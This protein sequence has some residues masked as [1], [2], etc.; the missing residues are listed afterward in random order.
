M[1]RIKE[2]LMDVEEKIVD[3]ID[4]GAK[5]DDEIYAYVNM[6]VSVSRKDVSNIVRTMMGECDE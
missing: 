6:F 1:S 4:L 3:A 5:T 2:Y